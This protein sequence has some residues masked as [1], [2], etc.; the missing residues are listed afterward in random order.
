MGGSSKY[1]HLLWYCCECGDGP[2]ANWQP[3][4]V[5]CGHIR[6]WKD[7]TDTGAGGPIDTYLPRQ[8]SSNK[9][10][11]EEVQ[12]EIRHARVNI[13]SASHVPLRP[14]KDNVSLVEKLSDD[15]SQPARSPISTGYGTDKEQTLS[16]DSDCRSTP[17]SEPNSPNYDA[18]IQERAHRLADLIL[19]KLRFSFDREA[20]IIKCIGGGGSQSS[21]SG[22]APGS[23]SSDKSKAL[24]KRPRGR[25]AP[26]DDPEDD[27]KNQGGSGSKKR[28]VPGE[29]K[30]ARVACIFWKRNRR[31]CKDRACAGPGFATIHRLKEHLGRRHRIFQCDRCSSAFA[32]DKK[33]S[34]HLRRDPPC[35]VQEPHEEW[36][37]NQDKWSR[38]APRTPAGTIEEQWARLYRICFPTVPQS[39]Y[40]SPYHNDNDDENISDDDDDDEGSDRERFIDF[41]SNELPQRVQDHLKKIFQKDLEG[42]LDRRV[43]ELQA[44]IEDNSFRSL[45]DESIQS[46]LEDLKMSFKPHRRPPKLPS[47]ELSTSPL[48]TIP[49][50]VNLQSL[51]QKSAVRDSAQAGSLNW[52][53]VTFETDLQ[54]FDLEESLRD[55]DWDLPE[56]IPQPET[57]Q[58]IDVSGHSFQPERTR[59][60]HNDSG[61]SS[62]GPMSGAWVC[63]SCSASNSELTVDFCPVCG[64]CDY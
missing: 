55:W 33:L 51:H 3:V 27:G 54:D 39:R 42:T 14:H 7:K 49:D 34:Q 61:G 40:P 4:C 16:T 37:I 25:G 1:N 6:C 19:H 12:E 48:G 60:K 10:A 18:L 43:Q 56:D 59:S 63:P 45:L 38:I 58:Q 29:S 32:E 2:I 13:A 50:D 23:G 9:E 28:K 31:K 17:A 53:D 44:L 24:S 30:E 8:Q 36:G 47:A 11:G 15:G 26:D 5:I 21:A 46:G 64:W 35:K 52:D 62:W 22:Q 41:C 20:G 57:S